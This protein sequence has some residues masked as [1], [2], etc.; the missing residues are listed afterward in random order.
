MFNGVREERYTEAMQENKSGATM[1]I[2]V[3]G[4]SARLAASEEFRVSGSQNGEAEEDEAAVERIGCKRRNIS[5]NSEASM[6]E[7]R[8]ASTP[9]EE[10]PRKRFQIPK[11]SREKKALQSISSDSRDF[12]EILKILHSSYLD[13][14]S[15]IHFTYQSAR[16]VHNEFLEKEFTE[17]RRQLKFDGRSEKELVE[18]YAFLLAD[19]DQVHSISEKGLLVGNSKL[20]TLGKPSMGVYLSKFA[21]LLQTNPLDGGATGC[22]FIFKVIKGKMKAVYDNFRINQE[23][24]GNVLDPAPKH[25]CHVL[26]NMNAV[27]ALLSYRA[28]ERTQYYFY[29][30]GF[31]EVLKKPRHV[32]PYAVVSFGYKTDQKTRRPSSPLS[33]PVNISVDHYNDRSSFILWRGQLLSKGKLLCHASLKSTSGPFFPF[34]LP[35]KIDLDIVMRL[36]QIKKRIPPLLFYKETH[37]NSKEVLKGGIYGRLYEVCNKTKT[38][39]ELQCLLQKMEKEKLALVKPVTDGGFLLFYFPTPMTASYGAQSKK[40]YPLHALFIYPTSRETL[41]PESCFKAPSFSVAASQEILPEQ[42]TFISALHYAILKSQTDTSD[43]FNIVVEKH[44]R[45]Y[46]KERAEGSHMHKDFIIRTYDQRLDSKKKLYVAPKDRNRILPSLNSYI[47]GSEAYTLPVGRAKE[48]IVENRRVQQ[49]SPVSDYEPIEDDHNLSTNATREVAHEGLSDNANYDHD[50]IKG[51]INLIYMKKNASSNS[52]TNSAPNSELK[53]KSTENSPE[54]KWKQTREN[55]LNDRDD[56]VDL[57]HSVSTLICALGGQ[58]TD[59]RQESA[60]MEPDTADA[61]NYNEQFEKS[62]EVN[63]INSI[64]KLFPEKKQAI[65]E[66]IDKVAFSLASDSVANNSAHYE[67]STYIQEQSMDHETS[68]TNPPVD[69]RVV[70]KEVVNDDV[71]DT[72]EIIQGP[73]SGY[74]SPCPSTPTEH[75]YPQQNSSSSVVESEMHWKLIPITGLNLIEDQS[76]YSS[77]KDDA[78]PNDPRVNHTR[79]SKGSGYSPLEEYRKGRRHSSRSDKGPY[80]DHMKKGHFKS[81]HCQDGLIENTVVEVY[82]K[83]SEQLKAV[84]REKDISFTGVST[85]LLSSE[86]RVVKLSDWLATQASEI[87]VHQYVDELRVKLDVVVN[88]RTRPT[89]INNPVDGSYESKGIVADLEHGQQ[90]YITA[91]NSD[92]KMDISQTEPSP[93]SESGHNGCIEHASSS[94]AVNA[95]PHRSPVSH[96]DTLPHASQDNILKNP[97]KAPILPDISTS[98][99]AI[100]DLIN[101]MN[102]EVFNNLVKIFSQVNKNIVKFYIHAEESAICDEIKDYLSKLGN[103]QC[104]PDQYVHSNA[105]SDKLLI[106]IQNEDIANSIHTIPSLTELKKRAGVSFAGVD[107]LEDLKNHT[108][109]ELFVSGGFIVCDDSVLNPDSIT[110]AKLEKFLLFLEQINNPEGKWQMK[111]HCKFQ[112]K[113]K[114]LGRTKSNALN[115]LALLNTYQKKHLVEILSY[116]N[117]DSQSRQAPQLECLIK[118]Q[119]QNIQQR[120]LIFLTEKNGSLFPNYVENGIVVTKMEEFMQKF[121][122]LVGHH[123]S[124]T[125]GIYLNLDTEE[126]PTALSKADVKEEEDMSLDSEDEAP[127]IEICTKSENCKTKRSEVASQSEAE[128]TQTE[129]PKSRSPITDSDCMQPVTPVSTGGSTTGDNS[130]AT[131]DDLSNNFRDYSN[132]QLGISHFNLLT[133]QTFLGSSVYPLLANQ[134]S[135]ENYFTNA[136]GQSTEQETVQRSEWDQK[137]N[138]K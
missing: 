53:T 18:S 25:E 103:V 109:N 8:G 127:E 41:Q 45:M 131:G 27:T 55:F 78:L 111:I 94:S 138:V 7:M 38:G 46:L 113:L 22:V 97:Q 2:N 34:K 47:H 74:A 105:V 110:A 83:F 52:E 35:D 125:D 66:D 5:V 19:E 102:P 99:T 62:L 37:S 100:K 77:P 92:L 43:N 33:G 29:E 60:E 123:S 126:K 36:E 118:L 28:F 51:L 136:Y 73:Y 44:V 119:V 13:A 57:A 89:N 93:S 49:F 42:P 61:E 114:E 16:M 20:T 3:G 11:K 75:F 98:H 135:G 23:S 117:C 82:N 86:D 137:W 26:K 79:Q 31:D 134:A 40:P 30:Y 91:G 130:S 120:H 80:R 21:D 70:E 14:N 56:T 132:R 17:K 6:I 4:G 90:G 71:L 9:T 87:P 76:V 32:C 116:H 54:T 59:L 12:E 48:L 85:P 108:Y 115:M 104:Y 65:H 81:K 129:G 39:K 1:D 67:Q 69:D 96:I 106:I 63:I 24:F 64:S 112:K 128:D 107:S 72:E 88:S 84:L 101:Q 58:D 122:S 10:P 95:L 68:V 124:S 133:H 121:T 50:R 15:K